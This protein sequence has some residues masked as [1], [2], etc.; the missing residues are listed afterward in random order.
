MKINHFLCGDILF[1]SLN[2]IETFLENF[3]R[4]MHFI[5]FFETSHNEELYTELFK[6]YGY[7]DYEFWRCDRPTFK[8]IRWFVSFF[9]K[10]PFV[11]E[12]L[13]WYKKIFLLTIWKAASFAKHPLVIK[14]T[15]IISR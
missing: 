4:P 8:Q 12:K 3:D 13:F 11:I 15:L 5:V 2:M 7:T 6:K 9:V 14:K 10:H 1:H